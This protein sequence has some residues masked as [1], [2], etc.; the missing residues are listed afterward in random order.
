ME[1]QR[2]TLVAWLRDA[3]AMERAALDNLRHQLRRETGNGKLEP[4]LQQQR[5]QH[6][7]HL[8]QVEECLQRLEAA[9][10]GLRDVAM[11]AA[12]LAEAW[13]ARLTHDDAVKNL[14]ATHA[15]AWF[16]VGSYVALTEAAEACGEAKVA[17]I[18]RTLASEREEAAQRLREALPEAARDYMRDPAPVGG[19]LPR[20]LPSA[21]RQN[22]KPA[23]AVAALAGAGVLAFMAINR[24]RSRISDFEQLYVSELQEILSAEDQIGELL[25]KVGRNCKHRELERLVLDQARE[26]RR[27]CRGLETLLENH[28][29]RPYRHEDQSVAAMTR[30]TRKVLT[31]AGRPAELGE[32]GLIASLQ[33]LAHYQY[34]A[35]GTAA[36]WAGDL[37]Y[38]DERSW[39]HG[40]A[41][42]KQAFDEDLNRIAKSVTN[43]AAGRATGHAAAAAS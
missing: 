13:A 37:G 12:G 19:A 26:A 21:V 24:R 39:L 7:R 29:Q 41:Q 28:G 11:R 33:R 34:A 17:E 40:A 35:F 25:E 8:E 15:Y 32:A 27:S 5:E 38:S 2:P 22:P 9:P 6:R 42:R 14:L 43:P 31:Q 3:H 16:G 1:Q 10:S 23:V 4:L 18:C 20:V 36:S 30:E